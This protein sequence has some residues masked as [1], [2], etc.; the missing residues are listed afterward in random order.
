M[1]ARL[2]ARC[3][4]GEGAADVNH[5][6]IAA[7]HPRLAYEFAAMMADLPERHW[8]RSAELARFPDFEAR[9]WILGQ[10]VTAQA[11][12]RLLAHRAAAPSRPW[13]D[14]SDYGCFQ[15]HKDL[16]GPKRLDEPPPKGQARRF[17]RLVWG[18]RMLPGLSATLSSL[19]NPG[20]A[21]QTLAADFEQLKELMELPRPPREAIQ[22][23]AASTADRLEP[24]IE[25]WSSKPPLSG[26]E[27]DALTA[28]LE[29]SPTRKSSRDWEELSQLCLGLESLA[30]SLQDAGDD[31]R[32]RAVRTRIDPLREALGFPMCK[33]NQN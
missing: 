19:T 29:A 18:A 8:S 32:A 17:A 4:V 5:D 11:S 25:R 6:L 24:F 7:G 1:R 33:K 21:Q 14:F 2:C 3:H 20:N 12:L 22:T 9:A 23:L 27:L 30:A 15:C 28:R 26:A 16:T 31:A 13:P 10:L